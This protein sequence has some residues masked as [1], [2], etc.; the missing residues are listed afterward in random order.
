MRNVASRTDGYALLL[1]SHLSTDARS[2]WLLDPIQIESQEVVIGLRRDFPVE[3]KRRGTRDRTPNPSGLA[4]AYLSACRSI[5]VAEEDCC[6]ATPH[7]I[8][9]GRPCQD[10]IV[11][12]LS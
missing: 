11:H 7:G 1:P 3:G 4:V 2:A 8:A 12:C 6:L 5:P 10:G 9:A